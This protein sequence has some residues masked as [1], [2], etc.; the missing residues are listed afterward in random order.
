LPEPRLHLEAVWEQAEPG[1]Q[2]FI[3]RYR[4]RKASTAGVP[5]ADLCA[6]IKMSVS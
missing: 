2:Y 4:E 6:D 1:T 5:V 3:R